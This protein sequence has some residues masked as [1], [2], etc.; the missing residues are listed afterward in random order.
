MS[1][2]NDNDT[3]VTASRAL[4][5]FVMHSMVHIPLD[6]LEPRFNVQLRREADALVGHLRAY[7]WAEEIQDDTATLTVE[8]PA[9]VWQAFKERWFPRS[10][11]RRWPVKTIS[12]S[13]S[14]RFV[15]KAT[16]PEFKYMAPPEFGRVVLKS[17]L[18]PG[19][20]RFRGDLP[21]EE[22]DE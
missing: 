19:E 18:T 12:R 14:Y 15:V 17:M 6:V 1:A 13:V 10:W 2:A 11:L 21:Q 7:V 5:R 8:W 3:V 22:G 16:L 4:E 9:T 20:T